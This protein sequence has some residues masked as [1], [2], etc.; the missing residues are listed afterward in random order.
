MDQLTDILNFFTAWIEALIAAIQH[1][2]EWIS[3]IPATDD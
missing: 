2:W 3:G 1:A